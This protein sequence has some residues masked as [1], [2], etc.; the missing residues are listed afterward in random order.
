MFHYKCEPTSEKEIVVLKKQKHKQ[1]QE[2]TYV[3][4]MLSQCPNSKGGATMLWPYSSRSSDS[5]LLSALGCLLALLV[6][7]GV[8]CEFSWFL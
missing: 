2:L 5:I 8:F 6:S 4:H 1:K 3:C 7:M